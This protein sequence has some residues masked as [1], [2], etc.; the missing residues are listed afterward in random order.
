MDHS[1]WL[2]LLFENLEKFEEEGRATVAY[3]RARRT[4]I[5]L[6]VPNRASVRGGRL[7][8]IST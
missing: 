6:S 4:K 5:D 1:T 7:P 8:E 3:L 2:N